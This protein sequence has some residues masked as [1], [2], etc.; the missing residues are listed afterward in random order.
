MIEHSARFNL[1][2]HVY[3]NN[4]RNG[5]IVDFDFVAKELKYSADENEDEAKIEPYDAL[6]LEQ[7]QKEAP[8]QIDSSSNRP[9]RH[10]DLN[11]ELHDDGVKANR[12]ARSDEKNGTSAASRIQ[13]HLSSVNQFISADVLNQVDKSQ[14]EDQVYYWVLCEQDENPIMAF[15]PEDL[16]TSATEAPSSKL[17]ENLDAWFAQTNIQYQH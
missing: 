2:D 17:L 5:V 11:L 4:E 6:A 12:L 16:V 1:F 15:V 7:L 3:V 13:M 14:I 10:L 9:T 8:Q